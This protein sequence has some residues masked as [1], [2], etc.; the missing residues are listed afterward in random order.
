VLRF[1]GKGDLSGLIDKAGK[2]NRRFAPVLA[3]PQ[4][5]EPR[6]ETPRAG[7]AGGFACSP[8]SCAG[9]AAYVDCPSREKPDDED[10][11]LAA[12]K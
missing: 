7:L 9:C 5:E 3:V 10:E 12:G 2:R 1:R 4:A 6:A 11:P 8:D